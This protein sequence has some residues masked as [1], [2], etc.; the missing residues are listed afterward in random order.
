MRNL[1]KMMKMIFV[2]GCQYEV[3][4][5]INIMR[6]PPRVPQEDLLPFWYCEYSRISTW[7]MILSTA[8]GTQQIECESDHLIQYG[9]I[10]PSLNIL[11]TAQ[12]TRV[13]TADRAELEVVVTAYR[14]RMFPVGFLP[15]R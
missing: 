6:P 8:T 4:Q 7:A 12:V 1:D 5:L 2:G 11:H 3:F 9:K 15:Y 13:Q 14:A 10:P